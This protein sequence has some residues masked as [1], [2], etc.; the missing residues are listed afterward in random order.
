MAVVRCLTG[1]VV[2]F[3]NQKQVW[4]FGLG[5]KAK[6]LRRHT[7]RRIRSAPLSEEERERL[8][9]AKYEGSPLHK[10]NPGDFGLTPPADPRR[11][12]NLCDEASIFRKAVGQDMKELSIIVKWPTRPPASDVESASVGSL[13]IEAGPEDD[14][15]VVTQVHD[16]IA[17]IVRDDVCVS[18]YALARW[19]LLNWWRLRFEPRRNSV[20]WLHAHS[21]ASI[22]DGYA[23]PPLTICGDGEFMELRQEAEEKPDVAAVR[24]LTDLACE[25]PAADFDDAVDELVSQV[26]ERL[27]S[28]E[29]EDKDLSGLQR[30]LQ[31]ER[32]DPRV[33]RRCSLQARAGFDPGDVPAGW[34][35]EVDELGKTTGED[36]LGEIAAVV[37]NVKGD[38][39]GVRQRLEDIRRSAREIDLSGLPTPEQSREGELPWQKGTR[40]ASQVRKLL[41]VESG[42]L[43]NKTLGEFLGLKVPAKQSLPRHP[44]DGAFQNNAGRARVGVPSEF[45]ANQRFHLARVMASSLLA[46]KGNPFLPVTHAYTAMQKSER[47]FAQE[48]LCPWKELLA[49]TDEKGVDEEGLAEASK[50]FGVSEYVVRST[51]VNKKRVS[52]DFLPDCLQ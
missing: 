14:R 44:L 42:P 41:G 12:K 28:C 24:Y 3:G 48:L 52:R 4:E 46:E 9:N 13:R 8:G 10:R 20:E 34:Q 22:G 19:L 29:I 23:W 26:R 31:E 25:V 37:P 51:L 33:S 43:S 49:F 7:R 38:L 17:Q 5:D 47:A 1:R 35:E 27:R 16:T 15:R 6:E 18:A 45:P 36:A 21:L 32:N 30:E 50:Y 2:W 40:L 11:D 39:A